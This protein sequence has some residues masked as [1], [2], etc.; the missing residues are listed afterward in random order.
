MPVNNDNTYSALETMPFGELLTAPLNACVDAQAQAAT[1]TTEYIKKVGFIYDSHDKVYRPVTVSFT[2][3]TELGAK[4][5]TLPLITVVP[6]PY[7]QIHDVNLVFSAEVSAV[8]GGHL[9][10]KVS[11]KNQTRRTT[12]EMEMTEQQSSAMDSSLRVNVNIKASTSDMPMGV[13]KL[14]Q[15]MQNY[16]SVKEAKDDKPQRI[17]SSRELKEHCINTSLSVPRGSSM[18]MSTASNEE[19]ND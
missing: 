15:V 19:T 5:F 4:R 8:D 13:S 1:A 18:K 17:T 3:N 10:G 7:L 6:V 11:T 9:E 14:L 16:I 12:T 2:Y